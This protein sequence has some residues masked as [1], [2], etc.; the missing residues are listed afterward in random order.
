MNDIPA[1][2]VMYTSGD[3]ILPTCKLWL[4]CCAAPDYVKAQI[5]I[6]EILHTNLD[7]DSSTFPISFKSCMIILLYFDDEGYGGG[8]S[9]RP[10]EG[11]REV[12][13]VE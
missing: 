13:D 8:T 10:D 12:L 2:L 6:L 1:D 11:S 9:S 3:Y 7:Y 4:V 5:S